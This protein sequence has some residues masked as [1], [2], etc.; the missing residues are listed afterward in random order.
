MIEQHK[1]MQMAAKQAATVYKRLLMLVIEVHV[2][3]DRRTRQLSDKEKK[4]IEQQKEQDNRIVYLMSISGKGG[5]SNKAENRERY[6]QNSNITLLDHLLSVTRGALMLA[7][8]D[9]LADNA[10]IDQDYL[11]KRLR[12]IAAI[13]FLHDLDKMEKLPR[14][15]DL[16]LDLVET[17]LIDYG[18]AEFLGETISLTAEQVRYLIEHAEDSQAHRS[19]PQHYPARIHEQDVKN[20]VG[21]ADK[22]DGTWQQYGAQGGL[23]KIIE[24]LQKHQGFRTQHLLDQW[25]SID[26]FDPHHPFLLDELQRYLSALS[27]RLA[28]IPP[29]LETHQDGRLFMLLPKVQAEKIQQQALQ[30]LCRR[31]PFNLDL[32]IPTTG[33]P[34]LLNGQPNYADY[35]AFLTDDTTCSARTLGRIFVIKAHLIPTITPPLDQ[36]LGSYG[37]APT[38]LGGGGQTK[39]PYPHPDE[40]SES[41]Q[42][43]LIKAATLVLALNLKVDKGKK[44][45]PDYD[46]REQ[47]LLAKLEQTRPE[48]IESI[49]DK[50][51]AQSR[52]TLTGLWLTTLAVNDSTLDNTIWGEQGLIQY[53]LEGDEE[54]AG[55]NQ[56]FSGE[57]ITILAA[58]KQHFSQLLN[59]KPIVIENERKIKGR[60]LFTDM[61]SDTLI[62]GKL[63]LHEVKVS[64]FSARDGKP[65]SITA[66]QKGLVPISNVSL[67]EHKF[68]AG[69]FK[70]QGGKPSGTPSLISSPIT[71]GLFAALVFNDEKKLNVLS[72]YDLSRKKIQKDKINYRGLEIYRQRYRMAR[73]ERL[74]EKLADQINLLRLLLTSCLRVGRPI[75]IF[76]GLPTFQKAFFYYD[77]MPSTLKQLV[78]YA[79][80]RLEQIPNA[81]KRLEM[82]RRLIETA[83]L[84]YDVVRLY[85]SPTTR[86]RAV[87]LSYCHLRDRDKLDQAIKYPLLADYHYLL[88]KNKMNETDNALV[89]LGR[90][91]ARI[92]KNPGARASTNDEILVFKLTLDTA[93]ALR[94]AGQAGRDSLIYGIAGELETNL[95]RK[96][97]A[98]ARKYRDDMPLKQACLQFAEQFVDTVWQGVLKQRPPSQSTRRVLGSVYRMAFMQASRT[99]KTE[100]TK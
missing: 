32:S 47:Q 22:L 57:G 50:Y 74:P 62:E 49:Q 34:E 59:K 68:R 69:V 54:K 75:H 93:M 51:D 18:I 56:F 6:L 20:Y 60:C 1:A 63:K 14:D 36:L 96:D 30:R 55:F 91:A 35:L 79:E 11:Q 41:A 92:Q 76:R 42:K 53:W 28:K 48:W 72:A 15:A 98:A 23:E 29:L 61:P 82:A 19:P 66:P 81:I 65:D 44:H 71:T 3:N 52:R 85:A 13:A 64:A 26:I 8:M 78:G 97:K 86:F 43:M 99:K 10:D 2:L 73:F 58:V 25:Q 45:V 40:L 89:H 24:R 37:L 46:A 31:L 27:V 90:A 95:V 12:V 94:A 80:L 39:T 17:T 21:L 9:I 38:W 33:V 84:G 87:C 16:T 70:L 88:E 83:G 100:S 5:W 77:A 4:A 67:A 7:A